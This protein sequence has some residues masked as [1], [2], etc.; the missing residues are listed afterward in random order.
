MSKKYLGRS[1]NLIQGA[2]VTPSTK[3]T[4]C[5]TL[6][7]KF[8]R[9]RQ[10]TLLRI[11]QTAKQLQREGITKDKIVKDASK[12]GCS[13][14]RI[15]MECREEGKSVVRSTTM[16]KV[17]LNTIVMKTLLRSV[18]G[19]AQNVLEQWKHN[20]SQRRDREWRK[21]FRKRMM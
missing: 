21:I 7:Q 9:E 12:R 10:S 8:L 2:T 16:M 11:P 18:R 15:C 13:L 14:K 1:F 3:Q 20:Q 19:Q 6:R 4:I 17:K 5:T